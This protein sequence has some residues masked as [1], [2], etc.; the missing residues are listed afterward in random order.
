M[1]MSYH[2][3]HNNDHNGYHDPNQT[4]TVHSHINNKY[5]IVKI[6]HMMNFI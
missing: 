5:I 2:S 4:S 3:N 6:I 1:T